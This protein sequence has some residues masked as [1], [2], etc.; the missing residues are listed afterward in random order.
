MP[1]LAWKDNRL[2]AEDMAPYDTTVMFTGPEITI[3]ELV[4]DTEA[5]CKGLEGK[6]KYLMIYCHGAPGYLQLCKE[7]LQY[8]DLPKL[9]S[10]KP[11][12]D[13]VSIHACQIARGQTGRAFCL[14]MAETLYAPVTGAVS[15]QGNTGVQ[16]I[17]GW[18][19]D[20][21]YDGKFYVHSP[22][23]EVTGPFTS[24]DSPIIHPSLY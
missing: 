8:K 3:A 13:E 24:D 14:K 1:T 9:K 19:D 21:K 6:A 5:W 12:F 4:S 20:S 16:R 22:T 17:Y 11:Y 2:T 10:L 18:E 15:L 7:G 23:G